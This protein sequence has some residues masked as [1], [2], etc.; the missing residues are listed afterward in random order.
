MKSCTGYLPLKVIVFGHHAPGIVWET[1]MP[2]TIASYTDR[3]ISLI[4]DYADIV[5][6]TLFGHA[7]RDDFRLPLS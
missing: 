5:V 3:M 4:S 1:G 7:H 2:N 6:G